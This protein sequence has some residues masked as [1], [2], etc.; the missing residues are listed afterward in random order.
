M[1]EWQPQNGRGYRVCLN[2]LTYEVI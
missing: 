1:F 2:T